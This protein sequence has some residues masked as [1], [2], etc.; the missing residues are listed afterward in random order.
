MVNG[1]GPAVVTLVTA[2]G[3]IPLLRSGHYSET[4]MQNSLTHAQINPV[5]LARQDMAVLGTAADPKRL[6]L[7]WSSDEQPDRGPEDVADVLATIDDL[8]IV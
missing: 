3:C 4:T 2:R 5:V 1:P 6:R 8:L 7:V